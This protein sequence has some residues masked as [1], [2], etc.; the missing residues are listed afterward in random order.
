MVMSRLCVAI[1]V[2]VVMCSKCCLQCALAVPKLGHWH[3]EK[4]LVILLLFLLLHVLQLALK[5]G[6]KVGGA[7]A[8]KTNQKLQSG[9]SFLFVILVGLLGMLVGYLLGG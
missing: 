3:V 2:T 8:L 1:R 9:F 6:S 4:N 7:Q 5:N